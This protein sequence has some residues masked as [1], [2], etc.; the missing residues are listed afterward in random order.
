P[1]RRHRRDQWPGFCQAVAAAAERRGWSFVADMNGEVENGYCAV[2]VSST[3]EQRISAA[4]A[5]LTPGVRARSNLSIMTD[6]T[7]ED[8][9][10][11]GAQAVGVTVR[12]NGVA[13]TYLARRVIV[14]A[15]ALHTPAFLQRAGIGAGA[16]LQKLG[17]PV[18][19]DRP[20][21]GANLQDHPCVSI[22]CYL[23]PGARQRPALKPHANL[24]LRY[25]SG[26][27]DCAPS[28]LYISVTNKTSWHAL[29]TALA[30]LAVCI[31]KPYSRG[32]VSIDS[33]DFKEPRIDF[34]LLSDPRDLQRLADGMTFAHELCG[35]RA[36]RS[37]VKDFF[38]SSYTERIRQLN[39]YSMK[40]RL[41]A[42]AGLALLEGPSSLRRWLLKNV[43]SP[44]ISLEQLFQ[45]R[46]ALEEWIKGKAVPFY[47]PIGTCRMGRSD[48]AMA[49]T[50]PRGEVYGVNGLF[51]AD[52]S[53]MPTI[54]RANTNLTTLMLA[55]KLSVQLRAI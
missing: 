23:E 51:V 40:N 35:D 5:Y 7:V 32:S 14:A 28:D 10:F 4:M 6:T 45:S 9:L 25:D 48:D 24:A 42:Y 11:D 16:A 29:G 12:R 33:K 41:R 19:A 31:Y 39:R 36:V 46:A 26:R 49:V 44:G 1:V 47:H 55:E 52:A 50:N 22:A 8:L 53:I 37:A 15:G 20:G 3:P 30:A 54:P 34:N 18:V 27:P 21:V 13:E 38:P 43:I 2:P 17:I